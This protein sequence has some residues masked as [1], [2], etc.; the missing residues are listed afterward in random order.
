MRLMG[1]ATIVGLG[2]LAGCAG[3]VGPGQ[4]ILDHPANPDA[5]QSPAPAASGTLTIDP[6]GAAP[7]VATTATAP[8]VAGL[9][10]CPMHPEVRSNNPNDR[11]PKCN[12]KINKPV[13]AASMPAGHEGHG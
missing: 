7:V 9:F 3:S 13:R 2:L 5:A 1:F 6:S 8:V 10:A 12:M 4:P 11:C